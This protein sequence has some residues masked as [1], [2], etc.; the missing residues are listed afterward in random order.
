MTEGGS[1]DRSIPIAAVEDELPSLIGIEDGMARLP[2]RGFKRV[3][4]G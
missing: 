1:I 3:R 2:I 4:A